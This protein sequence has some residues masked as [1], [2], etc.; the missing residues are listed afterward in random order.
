M[1]IVLQSSGG[2]SVTLQE[3][4]TASNVT[5]T[6]PAATGDVMVSGNIP[7]FNAYKSTDQNLTS[8]VTTKVTFDTEAFDTN[9]NFASSTFTPTVAGYY[10]LSFGADMYAT[11][12]TRGVL[13]AKKNGTTDQA[14]VGMWNIAASTEIVASGSTIVYANGTTDYFEIYAVMAGTSPKIY[15]TSNPS[16]TWFAGSLI[17]T[18]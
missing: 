14:Y 17:R 9:S 8:G 7:V 3:P 18:A 11:A 5:V 13:W 1:S 6:I 4:S 10:L 2:G 16:A 15:S 12:L